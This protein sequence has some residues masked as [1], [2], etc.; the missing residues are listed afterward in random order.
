MVALK[1]TTIVRVPLTEATKELK[2]VGVGRYA[3]VQVFFG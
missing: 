1:G 3:E 2:T